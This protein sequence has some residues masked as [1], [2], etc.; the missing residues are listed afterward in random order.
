MPTKEQVI[1]YLSRSGDDEVFTDNWTENEHGFI[2]YK[3]DGDK[4][5][6]FNVYGDGK[7][8]DEYVT[9][10]AEGLGCKK[11]IAATRRNPAPYERKYGY[12]VTGYIIEKEVNN[13]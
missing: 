2:S 7:Y 4:F 1:D 9:T 3:V 10:L 6:W 12:K 11:I 8:W 5:L 13:G